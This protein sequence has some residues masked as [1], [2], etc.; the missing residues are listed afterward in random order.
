MPKGAYIDDTGKEKPPRENDNIPIT[1]PAL[2]PTRREGA[3][4]SKITATP[5]EAMMSSNMANIM[6]HV[7]QC[8]GKYR[9]PYNTDCPSTPIAVKM[10][11]CGSSFPV[12]AITIELSEV[13]IQRRRGAV[14]YLYSYAVYCYHEYHQL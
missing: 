12:M 14:F 9:K 7:G 13:R 11:V 10:H 8:N 4:L 6:C 1:A 3:K 5:C 2:K